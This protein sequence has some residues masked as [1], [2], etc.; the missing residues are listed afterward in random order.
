MGTFP[1]NPNR[2][3]STTPSQHKSNTP[4]ISTKLFHGRQTSCYQQDTQY[5]IQK[6]NKKGRTEAKGPRLLGQ[7]SLSLRLCHGSISRRVSSSQVWYLFVPGA[8]VRLRSATMGISN[9]RPLS[10]I[11]IP[12]VETTNTGTQKPSRISER[13]SAFMDLVGSSILWQPPFGSRIEHHV[14]ECQAKSGVAGLCSGLIGYPS[15]SWH[16]SR[17][18]QTDE[19]QRPTSLRNSNKPTKSMNALTFSE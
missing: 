2:Q 4:N 17:C 16:G 19:K 11:S 3:T 8:W 10:K 1:G 9:Q 6:K 14:A 18:R 12:P 13:V 15:Y 7:R 5:F